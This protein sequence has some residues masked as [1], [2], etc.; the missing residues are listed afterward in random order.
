[1][2]T[3]KWKRVSPN[4][5]NDFDLIAANVETLDV[6]KMA[7]LLRAILNES[8]RGLTLSSRASKEFSRWLAQPQT[9]LKSEAYVQLSNWFMTQSGDR[10]SRVATRCEEFWDELFPCRPAERLSS[11]KAGQNHVVVPAEFE[12]FWQRI[13]EAQGEAT[14]R[15]DDRDPQSFVPVQP[16]PLNKPNSGTESGAAQ[17]LRATLD[18]DGLHFQV[19]G[20]ARALADFLQMLSGWDVNAKPRTE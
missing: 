18:K 1:M 3:L 11:P 7:E 16:G 14:Q 2:T 6:A 15:N 12:S 20:S 17:P 13:L 9:P 8:H 19:E 10:Q 5:V 4:S